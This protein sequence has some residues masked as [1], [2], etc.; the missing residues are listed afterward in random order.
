MLAL[1]LVGACRPPAAGDGRWRSVGGL[2]GD[3]ISFVEIQPAAAKDGA[4]YQDA[5]RRLCSPGRCF[6]VGF[7]AAGDPIPPS[8]NRQD[9]FRAGG[10][11][12]YRPLAVYVHQS[13]DFTNWDCE[14]AGVEAAPLSALCGEG[15]N[16]QYGAV[17]ALAAR[18]GWV[19]GCGLRP[20]GGRAIVRRFTEELDI[21]RRNQLTNDFERHFDA[22]TTGP[23]SPSDCKRL[24]PKI[25]Q[26]AERARAILEAAISARR[27]AAKP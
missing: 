12:P 26:S 5:I 17:L 13:G 15:V 3:F 25:E 6:Q 11:S 7:F 14:R 21:A 9:F 10:W 27:H 20:F 2:D 22:S 18:D 1:L 8:G 4:V 23:D 24:K 19:K 16:E